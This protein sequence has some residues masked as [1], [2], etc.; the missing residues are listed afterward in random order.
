M[1]QKTKSTLPADVKNAA[2]NPSGP[3]RGKK[4]VP[5]RQCMGCNEHKPKNQLVRIVRTPEGNLELDFKGKR[6]G[7]GA[8]ICPNAACLRKLK[9]SHRLDRVLECSIPDELYDSLEAAINQN[10]DNK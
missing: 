3:V 2:P 4:T 8:Y 1:D 6:N 9:K 10:A 5:V 7:R